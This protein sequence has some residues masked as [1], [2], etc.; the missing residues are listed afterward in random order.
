MLGCSRTRRRGSP[1]RGPIIPCN[2]RPIFI[3]A[4]SFYWLATVEWDIAVNTVDGKNAVKG[5]QWTSWCATMRTPTPHKWTDSAIEWRQMDFVWSF[6]P[7][8]I[9]LFGCKTVFR[10]Y[11]LPLVIMRNEAWVVWALGMPL[12][13]R[14][15]RTRT[16]N[17]PHLFK[18]NRN[19]YP[20]TLFF[21][22]SLF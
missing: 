11:S 6:V 2:G 18:S 21:P 1:L 14:F 22:R 19:A 12:H 3:A 20:F 10:Q 16:E 15:W 7:Q 8:L 5:L 4:A 17:I 13:A 9:P